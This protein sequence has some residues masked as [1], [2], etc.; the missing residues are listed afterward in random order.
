MKISEKCY[1]A[2]NWEEVSNTTEA[3]AEADMWKR[4]LVQDF[5]CARHSPLNCAR[6][7]GNLSEPQ[8][9]RQGEAME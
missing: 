7:C 9:L 4:Q 8:D 5:T 6:V 1:Q 2:N 3:E